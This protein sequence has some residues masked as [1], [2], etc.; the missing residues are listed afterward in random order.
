MEGTLEEVR[1]VQKTPQV[2]RGGMGVAHGVVAY[3]KMPRGGSRNG[4]PARNG[5]KDQQGGP[6]FP[7]GKNGRAGEQQFGV[8][9]L[10][11]WVVVVFCWVCVHAYFTVRLRWELSYVFD[12][13]TCTI[14]V[15][16]SRSRIAQKSS[17]ACATIDECSTSQIVDNVVVHCVRDP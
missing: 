12:I 1:V 7:H 17:M 4:K 3:R 2:P 5:G 8:V 10:R 15:H 16:E 13:H 11:I 9:C 14:V 6:K